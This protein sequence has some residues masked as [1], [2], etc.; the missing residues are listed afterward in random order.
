[1]ALEQPFA[2]QIGFHVGYSVKH[3][4]TFSSPIPVIRHHSKRPALNQSW[5]VSSARMLKTHQKERI[6]SAM[7][8]FQ[9]TC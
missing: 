9:Q 1:M 6:S 4:A 3:V 5:P 7:R 2:A 8:G